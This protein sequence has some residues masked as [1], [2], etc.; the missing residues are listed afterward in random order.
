MRRRQRD[1]NR[2]G[3]DW[4]RHDGRVTGAMTVTGSISRLSYE[5]SRQR[6]GFTLIELLVVIAIIGILAALLLPV[7]SKSR[8][9]ARKAA[10]ANNL[11]QIGL[12]NAMYMGDF[13]D[14]FPYAGRDFAG[15]FAGFG[16]DKA[17]YPYIQGGD[18]PSMAEWL[19]YTN[20]LATDLYQC[21][22]ASTERT[23]ALH[24][25]AAQD[26]AMPTIVNNSRNAIGLRAP[27]DWNS[28][29]GYSNSQTKF[30]RK[31]GN[32]PDA[33]GTILLT[34]L[35]KW[36][37]THAQGYGRDLQYPDIQMTIDPSNG[38]L[39]KHGDVLKVNYLMAAG[40]VSNHRYDADEII[41]TGS[42]FTPKGAWSIVEGD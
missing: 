24:N 18:A 15:G 30:D 26:Y 3:P 9:T 13:D 4:Q 40:N 7:L 16:W 38:T 14:N 22:A 35:E 31:G 32:V 23:A 27:F 8:G 20:G 19:T 34:E 5:R 6:H 10:C 17:L 36:N 42:T 29:P 39:T 37:N 1:W 25:R 33:T 28:S 2:F 21:P 41:G 11:K 12:A